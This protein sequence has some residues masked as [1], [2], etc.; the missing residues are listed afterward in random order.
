[1]KRKPVVAFCLLAIGLLIAVRLTS[2]QEPDL[3]RLPE[4]QTDGGQPLMEALKDR[5][6]SRAFS[7]AALPMQELSNL[8]WAAF[9]INR[10]ADSSPTTVTRPRPPRRI[11][12]RPGLGPIEGSDLSVPRAPTPFPTGHE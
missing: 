8:L 6:T 5:K 11:H 1:M 7:D 2:A 3:L 10:P 9:G 12:P 4:P